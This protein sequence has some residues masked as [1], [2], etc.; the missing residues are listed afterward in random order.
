MS[1]NEEK[2]YLR[3]LLRMLDG[4]AVNWNVR[5]IILDLLSVAG[6]V[7]VCYWVVKPL[8]SPDPVL[9]LMLIAT[10]VSGLMLGVV[11]LGRVMWP[12]GRL[13]K[14]YLDRDRLRARLDELER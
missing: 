8:G 6:I 12:H 9:I 3:T 14:R 4:R 5:L 7:I 1:P 13:V 2:K 11:A 10:F